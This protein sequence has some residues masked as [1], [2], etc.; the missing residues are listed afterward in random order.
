M[1]KTKRTIDWSRLYKN[2]GPIRWK[3]FLWMLVTGF[4]AVYSFKFALFLTQ[5]PVE[6]YRFSFVVLAAGVL[7]FM[8][9]GWNLWH[10][11]ISMSVQ[12]ILVVISVFYAISVLIVSLFSMA[13]NG[14]VNALVSEAV[15]VPVTVFNGVGNF[16]HQ[17]ISYPG[18]FYAFYRD[19][20]IGQSQE[21]AANEP[22][23][24]NLGQI[25]SQMSTGYKIGSTV[26]FSGSAGGACTLLGAA[27]NDL[28]KS[29]AIIIEGPRNIA[30]IL[31]W[32]V[33]NDLG[34]AWCPLDVLES[35]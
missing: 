14:F 28:F 26:R 11:L 3:Y 33:Q 16:Y 8:V 25:P 35:P 13:H 20:S 12:K 24:I 6:V 5:L 2:P 15:N 29:E 22:Q 21:I 19:D 27:S 32:L 7:L 17:V 31:M 18:E 30:S 34:S 10:W 4:L 9:W 23:I 1:T